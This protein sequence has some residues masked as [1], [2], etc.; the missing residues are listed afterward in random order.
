MFRLIMRTIMARRLRTALLVL[1]VLVV[2]GAFGV[3]LATVETTRI[4]VNEDLAQYWRTTYDILVRPPDSVSPIEKEHGLVQANHLS[5]LPGGITLQQYHSIAE[6]PGSCS[7]PPWMYPA[8]RAFIGSRMPPSSMMECAGTAWSARNSL[9]APRTAGS[10]HICL[11][12]RTT[13]GL[14]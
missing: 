14:H 5:Q 11:T 9:P 1:G 13:I 3:L 12:A 4:T 8:N 7:I 2:S 6:M 10:S